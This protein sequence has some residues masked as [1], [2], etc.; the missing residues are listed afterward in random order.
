MTNNQVEEEAA[1]FL[2]RTSSAQSREASEV[3]Y[4]RA[5]RKATASFR[6]LH[7]AVRLAEQS[8]QPK[9]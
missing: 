7:E 6:Q 8:P 4:R 1:R 9:S 3:R 2:V 5:L